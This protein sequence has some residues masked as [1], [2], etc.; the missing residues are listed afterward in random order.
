M[1]C[2]CCMLTDSLF[3]DSSGRNVVFSSS[4]QLSA[5]RKCATQN[6]SHTEV[7]YMGAVF[8]CYGIKHYILISYKYR[9]ISL[10]GAYYRVLGLRP[11]NV[12]IAFTA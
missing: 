11:E 4:G 5:F 6:F 10:Q 3:S 8:K 7:V 12:K 2:A 9:C 1:P